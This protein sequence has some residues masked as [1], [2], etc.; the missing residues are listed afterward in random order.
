MD[1][2]FRAQLPKDQQSE[3]VSLYRQLVTSYNPSTQ[4]G[5]FQ[6][7]IPYF[8]TTLKRR[9]LSNRVDSLLRQKIREKFTEKQRSQTQTQ[10]SE[11][12]KSK[13]RSILSLSLQDIDDLTP[14]I[15]AQT[16]DQ[17]KSF[18]FAGHDTTSI[19]LQWAFY[20][21]SR[22]P[23]ALNSTRNEVTQIFGPDPSPEIIKEALLSEQGGDALIQRMSYISAVIKEILRLYPPSGTARYQPPGSGFMVTLPDGKSLCLDGAVVYNCDT[24]VQRDEA[25]YGATKDEFYPERWL[26]D[27]DT[28]MATNSDNNNTSLDEKKEKTGRVPASAWRPF[29]RGPRN[30]IGQE[31]ANL[32]ARVVLA[33]SVCRYD[34][35]KVGRGAVKRGSDGKGVVNGNGQFEVVSEMYNVSSFFTY[36][37]LWLGVGRRGLTR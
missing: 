36:L 17:L 7:G 37:P 21:L 26:G 15:L 20:E 13:S 32:E 10:Q 19:L 28:S 3:I 18:L 16:S 6:W 27:T 30:C 1:E 34:F 23:R 31:L 14:S 5:S 33:C 22:T 25:V 12:K 2:D 9:S 11:T 8:S 35:T 29:E 24:I 4:G